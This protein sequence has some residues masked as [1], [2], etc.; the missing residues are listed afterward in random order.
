MGGQVAS[1]IIHTGSSDDEAFG[2]VLPNETFKRSRAF[3]GVKRFG[4]LYNAALGVE[5]DEMQSSVALV[6]VLL[7]LNLAS[8]QRDLGKV[9]SLK[10]SGLGLDN[11]H[12]LLK[13]RRE[14]GDR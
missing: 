10:A 8:I 9:T 14:F 2:N 7:N 12:L 4:C 1:A 3:V 13:T 11:Q 6:L 5:D